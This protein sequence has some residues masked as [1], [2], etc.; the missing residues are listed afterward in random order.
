VKHL[1]RILLNTL[2]VL[3]LIFFLATVV[4][5]IRSYV[6]ADRMEWLRSRNTGQT[7]GTLIK[8]R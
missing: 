8:I 6:V 3:S 4:L 2:T 7:V 1:F 5:W